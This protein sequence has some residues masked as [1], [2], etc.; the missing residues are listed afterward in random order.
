MSP[1]LVYRQTSNKSRSSVGNKIVDH[2]D[3]V[4]S[5]ALLLLHLFIDLT[6]WFNELHNDN[7]NTGREPFSIWDVVRV[8]ERFDSNPRCPLYSE[9]TIKTQVTKAMNKLKRRIRLLII[10]IAL[11]HQENTQIYKGKSDACVRKYELV[12]ESLLSHCW[13]AISFGVQ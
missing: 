7:C 9:F 2:W 12:A 13:I 6:P 4:E 5:S 3:V 10:Y 8:Y 11:C 1:K